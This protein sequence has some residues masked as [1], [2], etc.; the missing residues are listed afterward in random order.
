[1]KPRQRRSD[2][3][4]AAVVAAQNAAQ[5]PIEPP[6]HVTLPEAA[7]P[8]WRALML[9]RPRDRWN[10]AD[11]AVAAHLARAQADAER[12]QREID[13]EGDLLG[14]KLNPKHRLLETII[15][16]IVLL[17]RTLNVHADATVGRAADQVKPLHLEQ[18]ARA[19]ERDDLIPLMQ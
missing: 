5:A 7:A 2:S 3:I 12:L 4:T 19:I 16:R 9:N 10:D 17:S 11:L 13:A 1:M 6:E 14:E 8:F 18:Q 15:K